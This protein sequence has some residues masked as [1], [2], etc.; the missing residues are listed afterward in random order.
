MI[1][2]AAFVMKKRAVRQYRHAE[3]ETNAM[4]HASS[5]KMFLAWP[6]NCFTWF[7]DLGN[8]ENDQEDAVMDQNRINMPRPVRLSTAKEEESLVPDARGRLT[9]AQMV[10]HKLASMLESCPV[11]VSH[12]QDSI[13]RRPR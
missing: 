12:L 1:R 13:K 11:L 10:E 5:G 9:P 8:V 6:A 7:L 4:D 3:S 2:G